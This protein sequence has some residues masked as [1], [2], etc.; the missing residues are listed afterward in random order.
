MCTIFWTL[1]VFYI[2]Q[3]ALSFGTTFSQPY[4]RETTTAEPQWWYS[5]L[6]SPVNTPIFLARSCLSRQGRAGLPG[7]RKDRLPLHTCLLKAL[8]SMKTLGQRRAAGEEEYSSREATAG[9]SG[10]TT[11]TEEVGV[12]TRATTGNKRLYSQ[13]RKLFVARILQISDT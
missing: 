10:G 3:T 1:L 7:V 4:N 11:T 6:V 13:H 8:S 12:F 2:R 9:W 5:G